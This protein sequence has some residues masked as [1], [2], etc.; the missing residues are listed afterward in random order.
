M[1]RNRTRD[2]FTPPHSCGFPEGL[3]DQPFTAGSKRPVNLAGGFSLLH[4]RLKP[5]AFAAEALD[6]KHAEHAVMEHWLSP[7][8]R[9]RPV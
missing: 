7:P 9:K 3:L 5:I 1:R 8:G 4:K 6:E 2:V